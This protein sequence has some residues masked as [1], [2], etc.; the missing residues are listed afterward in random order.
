MLRDYIQDTAVKT[1]VHQITRYDTEVK[2]L[3]K[4]DGRWE[5]RT[6]V[7]QHNDAGLVERKTEYSVQDLL[8]INDCQTY[9]T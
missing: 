8:T 5:V 2:R 4:L 3:L 9:N 1:G 6:V 7:L